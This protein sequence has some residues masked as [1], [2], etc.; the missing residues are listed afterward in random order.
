MSSRDNVTR[1]MTQDGSFRIIA[2]TVDRT[3]R[4]I[5]T[6]QRADDLQARALTE[7]LMAAILVRETS[8]PDK[9]VQVTLLSPSNGS[10]VAESRPDGSCRGFINPGHEAPNPEQTLFQVAYHRRDGNL[11]QSTVAVDP[12]IEVADAL[13][14]YLQSSVQ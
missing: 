4:A 1:A 12:S 6:A 11:H 3:A 13:M 9:R 5:A 2:T 14:L 7:L 8:A 10:L